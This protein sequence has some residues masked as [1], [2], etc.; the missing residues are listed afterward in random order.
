MV[1]Y[2]AESISSG[3]HTAQ[4]QSPWDII[5]RRVNLSGVS[6]CTDAQSQSLRGIILHRVNLP[7]VWD[8]GSQQLFL[9]TFAQ[10][11]KGILSHKWMLIFITL[12]KSY[13]LHLCQ[14]I[15]GWNIFA[16]LKFKI[17]QW[18]LNQNQKYFNPLVSGQGWFE[19]W[20]KWRKNLVGDVMRFS[21]LFIKKKLHLGPIWT[22][23]IGFAKFFIFRKIFEKNDPELLT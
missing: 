18:K 15:L 13:I 11:F 21:S 8:P 16:Q 17:T 9:K 1:F 5:L 19:W 20:K 4:S 2:C 6:Y 23:K 3:Y 14:K 10:A 7:G 12:I 22:G